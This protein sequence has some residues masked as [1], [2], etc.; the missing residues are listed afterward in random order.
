MRNFSDQQDEVCLNRDLV[1][2][3]QSSNESPQSFYDK[4]LHILNLLC[5]YV[6]LHESTEEGKHLKRQLY[7]NLTLKTFLSGL[8]EPIGT[9]IRCMKPISLSEA[10]Q[11]VL[12]EENVHYLQNP[13]RNNHRTQPFK[14]NSRPVYDFKPNYQSPIQNQ[15]RNFNSLSSSSQ[16]FNS[17]T[18]NNLFTRQNNFPSQPIPI[19]PRTTYQKIPRASQVFN[20]PNQ[21]VNVFMPNPNANFPK[22]TPMSISTRATVSNTQNQPIYKRPP[23]STNNFR[24]SKRPN[25]TSEELY[26]VDI[27]EN[28]DIE[29]WEYLNN[30]YND[31]D[32]TTDQLYLNNSNSNNDDRVDRNENF[33]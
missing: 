27:Q 7:Q 20:R 4:C 8:K 19:N 25:Y 1:M 3:R 17:Q 18:P 30:N 6:N 12:Q 24:Q 15:N 9:T 16:T 13:S 21:N 10:M 29:N 23:P 26:N 33:R 5:S 31:S 22:P 2:L 28:Y 11:F 14:N 32:H